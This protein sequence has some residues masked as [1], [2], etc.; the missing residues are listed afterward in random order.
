MML[1]TAIMKDER[2]W[3]GL[4][5]RWIS[6]SPR[7]GNGNIPLSHFLPFCLVAAPLMLTV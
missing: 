4:A 7:L 6:A 2:R 5:E 1:L 3:P